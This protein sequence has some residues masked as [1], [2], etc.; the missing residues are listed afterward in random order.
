MSRSAIERRL[1]W[2]FLPLAMPTSSFAS[3]ADVERSGTS[4]EALRRLE[5]EQ[6][7]DLVAMEQELARPVRDVVV[8]V[9][10]GVLRDVGA[11][12]PRLAALDAR[13]RPRRCSPVRSDALDLGAG[14]HEARL[15]GVLDGVVVACSAVEGDRLVGHRSSGH[16]LR[17]M[18]RGG[19]H[20]KSRPFRPALPSLHHAKLC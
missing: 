5:P 14:Q 17:R 9:S 19:G 6:L 20:G 3:R 4:G 12:Q 10:L 18:R 11:D 7:G 13:R 15:E 1:S 2:V 16:A 8:A